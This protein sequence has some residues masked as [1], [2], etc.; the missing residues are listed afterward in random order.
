MQNGSDPTHEMQ[1]IG[2]L[3]K[4]RRRLR[5]PL[6]GIPECKHLA[7]FLET[8]TYGFMAPWYRVA[9]ENLLFAVQY[10][11]HSAVPGDIAEFGCQS[12]RTATVISATMKLM[13]AKKTLH[14]FDSFEGMPESVHE[15]DK[16]NEHVKSGVWGKGT[17]K[18]ISPES[19]RRK[20][21]KYLPSDLIKIHKGW[22]SESLPRLPQGTKFAMLHIDCDLYLSALDVLDFVFK[23]R[24]LSDGAIILFDDWDCNRASNEH[25]ERRAWRE[26][27]E[28]YKVL[29]T[30]SG[31][32]G[33]AGHKFIV[34][35]YS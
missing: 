8:A 23:S 25:G 19:L 4:I 11:V 24:A 9:A 5:S 21:E 1:E 29:A 18:A 31:G 28:K 3:E 13:R 2:L 17:L 26:A 20:C 7:G 6:A 15:A 27:C 12:G 35:R 30:D 22:F 14:L 16:E 10:T 34:H 33:F 32:Y